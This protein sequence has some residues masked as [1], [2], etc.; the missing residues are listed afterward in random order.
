VHARDSGVKF[1]ELLVFEQ[2]YINPPSSPTGGSFS[3]FSLL[4]CYPL[5]AYPISPFLL[6]FLNIF[7]E[8]LRGDL[9]L[10]FHQSKSSLSGEIYYI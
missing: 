3:N 1:L 7:E 9:D 5:I 10:L 2:A 8:K 6:C 4:H